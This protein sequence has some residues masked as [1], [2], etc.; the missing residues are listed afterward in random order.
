MVARVTMTAII[1]FGDKHPSFP[2]SDGLRVHASSGTFVPVNLSLNFPICKVA[3]LP[4]CEDCVIH[5]HSH[6]HRV[7]L[8]HSVPTA[9]SGTQEVV[10]KCKLLLISLAIRGGRAVDVCPCHLPLLS[11]VPAGWTR[12]WS[13]DARLILTDQTLSTLEYLPSSSLCGQMTRS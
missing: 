12:A 9:V 7:C 13:A 5:T 11:Y 1:C 3:F 4:G 8:W 2:S 10:N 6:T